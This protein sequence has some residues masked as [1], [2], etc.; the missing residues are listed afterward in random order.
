MA[1]EIE[2]PLHNGNTIRPGPMYGTTVTTNG[3]TGAPSPYSSKENL[4]PSDQNIFQRL[5]T[6]LTK[7][8]NLDA[9]SNARRT[10]TT[11]SGVFAPVALSMFGTLLFQRIG[12]WP[13]VTLFISTYKSLL[14]QTYFHLYVFVQ[15]LFNSIQFNS[16]TL[17]TDTSNGV[18]WIYDDM[19]VR[20]FG[21]MVIE[22][23]NDLGIEQVYSQNRNYRSR[24]I[25]W[26]RLYT[27]F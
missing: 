8:A 24:T 11:I 7:L 14:H 23:L 16:K 9:G 15:S 21:G 26:H 20:E 2:T 4:V 27:Y 25:S 10:L 3:S 17:F 18:W 12:K 19:N 22:L 13:M 1:T 6:R 5:Q